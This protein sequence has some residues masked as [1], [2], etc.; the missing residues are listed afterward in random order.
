MGEGSR[1]KFTKYVILLFSD[2]FALS[3]VMSSLVS[4]SRKARTSLFCALTL[5]TH[6][7][8]DPS[9]ASAQILP[10]PEALVYC[11]NDTKGT[12][13]VEDKGEEESFSHSPSVRKEDAPS[14]QESATSTKEADENKSV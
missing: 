9:L 3:M 11:M 8:L 6:F 7:A 12:E 10:P 5:T 13:Q 2:L 14:H 4:A 1:G